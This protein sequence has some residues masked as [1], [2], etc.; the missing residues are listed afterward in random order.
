MTQQRIL[1]TCQKCGEEVGEGEQDLHGRHAI[2]GGSLDPNGIC[3]DDD[4][5][6]PDPKET[7]R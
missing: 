5:A 1:Y 2:C 3:E 4:L 7:Q 6:T